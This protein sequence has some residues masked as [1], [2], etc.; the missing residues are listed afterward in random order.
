MT[1]VDGRLHVGPPVDLHKFTLEDA[2][3]ALDLLASGRATGKVVIR[4]G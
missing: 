4:M 3:A 2:Q 1:K